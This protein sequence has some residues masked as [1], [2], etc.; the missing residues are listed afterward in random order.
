MTRVLKLVGAGIGAAAAVATAFFLHPRSGARRRAVAGAAIRRE[1]ANVATLIGSAQPR[2]RLGRRSG[3]K[4]EERTRIALI[5]TFGDAGDLIAVRAHRGVVTLRGEVDDMVDISR[6][7]AAVRSI[8]GV[9][10]VDNLLRL[11]LPGR[12]RPRVLT[13]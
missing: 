4:I 2:R 6:Y 3:D 11:R 7:E 5:A 8:P 10:D 9:H 12:G 13:A 1:S